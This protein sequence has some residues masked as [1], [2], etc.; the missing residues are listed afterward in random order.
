M[1]FSA[2]LPQQLEAFLSRLSAEI[3]PEAVEGKSVD[4][5]TPYER[6]DS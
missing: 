6:T 4:A 1:K 5:G 2:G 3:G